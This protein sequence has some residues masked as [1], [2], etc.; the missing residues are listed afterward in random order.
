[1]ERQSKERLCQEKDRLETLL[2]YTLQKRGLQWFGHVQRM[3][4]VSRAIGKHYTGYQ[5]K[6]GKEEDRGL[7]GE[8]Q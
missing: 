4:N 7:H 5:L 2:E 6:R 1:M 8:T 3:E